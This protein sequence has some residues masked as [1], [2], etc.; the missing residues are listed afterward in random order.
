MAQGFLVSFK[1][2][3]FFNEE[4]QLVKSRALR[5]SRSTEKQKQIS[6]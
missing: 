5:M 3:I 6:F 4:N 2:F 1:I